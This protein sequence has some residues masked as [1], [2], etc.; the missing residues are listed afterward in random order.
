MKKT[1]SVSIRVGIGILVLTL[2]A[3]AVADRPLDN[4]PASLTQKLRVQKFRLYVSGENLLIM[5]DHM[6]ELGFDPETSSYW[7]YP[8]QRA[9]NCGLVLTF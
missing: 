2:S 3:K 9:F 6:K 1:L 4:L 8:Q 7:Y 5:Y